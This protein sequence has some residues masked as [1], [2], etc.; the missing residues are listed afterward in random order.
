MEQLRICGRCRQEFSGPMSKG[1]CQPCYKQTRPPKPPKPA[2][3]HPEKNAY[4]K[5]LCRSCY[6]VQ[7]TRRASCHPDRPHLALGLC[8]ECYYKQYWT[9]EKMKK[10]NSLPSVKLA[11]QRYSKTEK[12]KA[13]AQRCLDNTDPDRSKLA[14]RSRASHLKKAYGL[15]LEDYEALVALQRGKCFICGS[16][17]PGGKVSRYMESRFAVDHCHET[18]KL[19][20]LLCKSCNQ[21]LGLFKDNIASLERAILYLRYS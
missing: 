3:C 11:R 15:E 7:K 4:R 14:K 19:R 17:D 16:T 5:G 20:G 6:E 18:G 10:N 9:P 8:S 12:G 1:M 21:G 2:I 13:A